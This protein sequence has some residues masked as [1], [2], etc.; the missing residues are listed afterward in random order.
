MVNSAGGP[1][2]PKRARPHPFPEEP[3]SLKSV[4]PQW[5][6][7]R[8]KET[9]TSPQ[10]LIFSLI[11]GKQGEPGTQIPHPC[12]NA[13]QSVQ[14]GRQQPICE[15][16]AINSAARVPSSHGGSHWFESSIAHQPENLTLADP[17]ERQVFLLM[18]LARLT[19]TF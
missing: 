6:Q 12:C 18:T 16:R 7:N 17:R 9:N 10:F 14:N 1:N 3:I 8:S 19:D 13:A 2:T 4:K 11:Q 15:T 5:R